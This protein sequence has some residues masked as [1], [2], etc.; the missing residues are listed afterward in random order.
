A[1][2][3]GALLWAAQDRELAVVAA[4]VAAKRLA[5]VMVDN[6]R[7]LDACEAVDRALMWLE[8]PHTPAAVT[9]LAAA[10]ATLSGVLFTRGKALMGLGQ[11]ES[12]VQ[13]L[14]ASLAAAPEALPPPLVARAEAL[15]QLG[16][17]DAAARDYE[18]AAE[19]FDAAR[20]KRLAAECRGR[21]AI[22]KFETGDV[23]RAIKVLPLLDRRL[24]AAFIEH[25]IPMPLSHI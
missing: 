4:A 12:A 3:C 15:S 11:W 6:G 8:R 10:G 23:V 18:S 21:A 19:V 16:E 9:A 5:S 13:E 24:C 20:Q 22:A 25:R 17:W 14:S 7:W 1:R 2:F